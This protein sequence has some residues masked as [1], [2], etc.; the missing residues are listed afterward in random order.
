MACETCSKVSQKS[1]KVIHRLPCLRWILTETTICRAEG[2][3][4]TRRWSGTEMKNLGANDWESDSIRT[5]QVKLRG[6]SK[7]VEFIVKKFKPIP[8][9]CTHKVWRDTDGNIQITELPPYAFR[10]I[11]EAADAYHKFLAMYWLSALDEFIQNKE[12]DG[13]VRETY[14]LM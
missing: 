13:L 4:L 10:D 14:R 1:K 3:Q 7:P 5:V 6:F 9:D 8:G 12:V 11:N 2:V